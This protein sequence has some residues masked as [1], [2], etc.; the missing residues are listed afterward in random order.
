MLRFY[1]IFLLLFINDAIA[2]QPIHGVI[3]PYYTLAGADSYLIENENGKKF[4]SIEDFKGYD[5]SFP[6][7]KYIIDPIGIEVKD[8]NA[9]YPSILARGVLVLQSYNLKTGI[10]E[11]K[12]TL[13]N[14]VSSEDHFLP[15]SR[16]KKDT[17]IKGKVSFDIDNNS[18]TLLRGQYDQSTKKIIPLKSKNTILFIE[19]YF[20]TGIMLG[21]INAVNGIPITITSSTP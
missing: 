16:R 9:T 18:Y 17:P 13:D 8:K 12:L 20:E 4:N 5:F 14:I 10:F 2:I 19:K 21:R 15:W 6:K 3:P 7:K 11:F 1:I